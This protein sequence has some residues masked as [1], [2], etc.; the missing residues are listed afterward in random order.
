[1]PSCTLDGKFDARQC[2]GSMCYCVDVESG[3]QA[4]G[5]EVF[6]PFDPKCYG[7]DVGFVSVVVVVVVVACGD[8][9]GCV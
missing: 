9:G 1:M 5:S 4:A 7:M 6:V 2:S 8:I 3:V